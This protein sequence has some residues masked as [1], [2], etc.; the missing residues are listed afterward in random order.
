MY[1]GKIRKEAKKSTPRLIFDKIFGKMCSLSPKT[2]VVHTL[3]NFQVKPSRRTK[4]AD[5][6][7]GLATWLSTRSLSANRGR[8]RASERAAEEKISFGF[9]AVFEN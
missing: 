9:C 4:V 7:E 6:D 3:L 1:A 8:E 5:S 2:L